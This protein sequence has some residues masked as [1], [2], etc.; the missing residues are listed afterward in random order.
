MAG[1]AAAEGRAE[2]ALRL[3]G[4]A[5]ELRTRLRLEP[6][7]IEEETLA[8]RLAPV[9]RAQEAAWLEGRSLS[10]DQA[11]AHALEDEPAD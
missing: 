2:R 8:H 10:L 7:P 4:A 11:I 3:A 1:V 9:W 6:W 5:A